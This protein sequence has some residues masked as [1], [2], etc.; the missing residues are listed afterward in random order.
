MNKLV[1]FP[2]FPLQQADSKESKNR[3]C[4]K[5]ENDTRSTHWRADDPLLVTTSF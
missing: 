4:V 3:E 2:F 1:A 5:A